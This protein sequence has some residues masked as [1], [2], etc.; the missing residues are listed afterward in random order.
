MK[1]YSIKIEIDAVV[2]AFSPEDAKEY[3]SDIFGTD[4]E[5]ILVKIKKIEEV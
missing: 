1:K 5:I 2:E 3:V 4:E